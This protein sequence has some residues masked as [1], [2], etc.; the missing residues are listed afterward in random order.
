M[1][2]D[3]EKID[4]IQA[5]QMPGT[6]DA[7]VWCFLFSSITSIQ[8]LDFSVTLILFCFNVGSEIYNK[9]DFC[10][11]LHKSCNHSAGKDSFGCPKKENHASW[12]TEVVASLYIS[13]WVHTSSS[14]PSG[15]Y[16]WRWNGFWKN[17]STSPVFVWSGLLSFIKALTIRKSKIFPSYINL[18]Y[19]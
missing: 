5:F 1:V 16:H 4:F 18:L 14:R 19:W 12:D 13:R 10:C 11:L 9:M 6:S 3:D 17:H 7:E 15:A 2:L 8:R